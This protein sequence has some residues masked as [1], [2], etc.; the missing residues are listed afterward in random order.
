M[1]IFSRS[2]RGALPRGALLLIVFA[3]ACVFVPGLFW[4]GTTFSRSLDDS[5]LVERLAPEATPRDV[6]HGIEELSRRFLEG[7]PGMDRWAEDLIRVSRRPEEAVR[8]GAA[9]CMQFDAT[10]TSFT[11]RLRE[12]VD[13]DPSPLARRNAATSLARAGD[14]AAL[15]VLRAMLRPFEVAAP[16]AGTIDDLP[17]VERPVEEGMT[18]ARILRADGVLT[19][20][21]A[22]VPGTVDEVLVD[23]GSA[24]GTGVPIVRIR[25]GADHVANALAGL[26]FVGEGSDRELIR[27]F[28]DTRAGYPDEVRAA[29]DWALRQLD[30]RSGR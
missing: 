13:A 29:A 21:R 22:P 24:V 3:A 28:A 6:Q 4:W 19:D 7:R 27:S 8:I 12:M 1:R 11:E 26:G 20:V 5:E 10:R 23:D 30:A 25:P 2:E 15:P 14:A 16:A 18:L 17:S 9:W